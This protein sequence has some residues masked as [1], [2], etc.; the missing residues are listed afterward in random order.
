LGDSYARHVAKS[1]REAS[2]RVRDAEHRAGVVC[3]RLGEARKYMDEKGISDWQLRELLAQV[4]QERQAG[5]VVD[6]LRTTHE[7]LSALL[8]AWP[9]EYKMKGQ[10]DEQGEDDGVV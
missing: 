5:R 3:E 2:R 7:K 10:S 9:D 1:L 4:R 6:D 8:A